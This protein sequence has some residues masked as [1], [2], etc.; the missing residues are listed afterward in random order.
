MK[1]V[2]EMNKILHAHYTALYLTKTKKVLETNKVKNI[3]IMR[4]T[5]FHK[6][7]T[8]V[9]GIEHC[10]QF[11]QKVQGVFKVYGV[12]DGD[13]VPAG[14]PILVIEGDY[15]KIAEYESVIDGILARESS[16]CNHTKRILKYIKPS[17]LICMADRADLYLAQPYDGYAAWIGGMRTFTTK[18]HVELI[19]N[20]SGVKVVGTMPHA[21]IQQFNGNL[22]KALWAYHKTFPNEKLSALIDYHDDV[23]GD[24]KKIDKQLRPLLTS[25]RIDTSIRMCD[26][27]L[28]NKKENYGVCKQL[29][30]NARKALDANDMK[31]VN[32]IVSS[33]F[34]CKKIKEFVKAKVPAD[35]YGVGASLLKVNVNITGDLVY[36][37]NRPEAKTG[38]EVKIDHKDLNKLNIYI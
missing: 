21:L 18:G 13:L 27:S 22:N 14:K 29:V 38:R 25:I 35:F 30:I 19:P 4:F 3:S 31:H 12:K 33:G 5:H 11:L 36:L 20:M 17:Q 2:H 8:Y 24:I 9:C 1:K 10:V 16:V 32:I 15:S 7:P 23:V 34:T 28:P 26:K 6:E 37:N